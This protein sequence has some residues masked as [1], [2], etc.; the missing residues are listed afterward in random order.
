MI[1]NDMLSISIVR[2][3]LKPPLSFLLAGQP[4]FLDPHQRARGHIPPPYFLNGQDSDI[5]CERHN[6]FLNVDL[7]CRAMFLI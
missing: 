2:S 5:A 7:D 4:S 6:S 3:R 1:S